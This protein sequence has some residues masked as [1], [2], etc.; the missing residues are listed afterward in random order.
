[1]SSRTKPRSTRILVVGGGHA[2][3]EAALAAAR[4]GAQVTL[5][6]QS[7]DTI[8]QMSCNPAIGGIGKS[9][10]VREIDAL[11]G[12]MGAAADAAGIHWRTLNT[13]RGAAVRATRAQAD[14]NLYREAARHQLE[15]EPRISLFQGEVVDLVLRNGQLAGAR[16]ALGFELGC[17]ALILTAGTFLAGVMHTGSQRSRGGRAGGSAASRLADAMRDYDLPSGR[18]KTG[19]PPRLDGATIDFSKTTPQPGECPPPRFCLLGAPAQRPQQKL[20]HI[21]QTTTH[22]HD[23]VR[24]ALPE[25]P[26]HNGAINGPGPRYCPSI[27]DK[28]T[29]FAARTSH[30]VFLE[31]EGL[32]SNEIYPN[33]IS[34]SLPLQAQIAIV[35]SIP[36]L[37]QTRITRPGYAVEY[38][39]YDPRALTPALAAKNIPGLFLAGQI[40]GTTG[41]EEA[42]A[43]G[44]LAGANAVLYANR[45][46]P[47]W[48]GRDE[49]YLGV[50]TD[51]LTTSGVTEPYRMFTSRAEF[52]LRLR[53]GNADFRL[54]EIGRRIGLVTE[55]RWR[56]YCQR[57]DAIERE[58]GSLTQ[59]SVADL[60]L[61]G[62]APGLT[63]AAWLRRPEASYALLCAARNN[64]LDDILAGAEVEA[65]CK[66]AGLIERQK[67]EV[68]KTRAS[69]AL[70]L[71]ANLDY[72]K[73]PG[74]S[75]EAS[76]KLGREGP[77]TLGQ[78]AAI[79]GVT[80][81]AMAVL[82]LHLESSVRSGPG[83]G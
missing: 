62:V 29:R 26:L 30:N 38:D 34:T 6:T 10:L 66:Y 21:T 36:G 59:L 5:I 39:F 32:A 56:A 45:E 72:A 58:A 61:P 25:S 64:G 48:P 23:L 28:V 53:E 69:A 70:R 8:G 37:E 1:M 55:R 11:D 74:L 46:E 47:W 20:C 77:A 27:E 22:T 13:S 71:P 65:R 44:L 7:I 63:A 51:D 78:A 16:L 54:T 9:H 60:N 43:Q 52:R 35:R 19:T 4:M 79:S 12:A 24:A 15:R 82:R 50:L 41:Y 81:A 18:L 80:P 68:A 75:T 40:N 17:D 73:I 67:I 49:S 76:E 3:L 2:G 31:P 42:A 33:G 14:R 83:N 57:R